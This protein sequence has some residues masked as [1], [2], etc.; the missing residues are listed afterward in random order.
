MTLEKC[1][2]LIKAG[3]AQAVLGLMMFY[4]KRRVAGHGRDRPLELS[5]PQRCVPRI[6]AS[7]SSSRLSVPFVRAV[8]SRR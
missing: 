6:L 4:K 2:W 7:F 3:V 1:K 5:L 8:R